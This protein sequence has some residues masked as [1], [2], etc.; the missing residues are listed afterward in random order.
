MAANVLFIPSFSLPPGAGGAVGGR[1]PIVIEL[2][3]VA[4]GLGP[5]IPSRPVKLFELAL[6]GVGG[7]LGSVARYLASGLVQRMDLWGSFPAGTL[8]VNVVGCAVLGV[9]GGLSDAR[10]LFGSSG[11]LL[12]FIGVLGGFT[13]FSTFSYETM[14]LLRGGEALKAALNVG[15]SLL[16]CLAGTWLGYGVT[17][18]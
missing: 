6:V 10:F 13:T 16:L 14:A 12:L 11:R 7:A 8:V 15:A 17:S 9:L 2:T 3:G 4:E 5:V 1:R 18:R